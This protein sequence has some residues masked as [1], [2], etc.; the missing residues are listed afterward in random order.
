[1]AVC[2][3]AYMT[4]LTFEGIST[5]LC[6]EFYTSKA[7]TACDHKILCFLK[8]RNKGKRNKT[9]DM[10]KKIMNQRQTVGEKLIAI[11]KNRFALLIRF[12]IENNRSTLLP[13]L[14]TM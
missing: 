8:Q 2:I 12:V 1:M 3:N 10:E 5:L 13:P 14:Y 4:C 6:I 11:Y 9:E 7:E